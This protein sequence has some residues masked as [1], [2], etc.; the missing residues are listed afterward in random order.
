MDLSPR[1]A[2]ALELNTMKVEVVMP[3]MAGMESTANTMSVLSMTR[4]AMN[5]GV[6]QSRCLPLSSAMRTKNLSP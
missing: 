6:A 2:K 3:S 4:R 5:I 1:T